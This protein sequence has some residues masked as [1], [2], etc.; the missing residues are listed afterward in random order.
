M[1][2]ALFWPGR[3]GAQPVGDLAVAATALFVAVNGFISPTYLRHYCP[4]DDSGY[5]VDGVEERYF[6]LANFVTAMLGLALVLGEMAAVFGSQ[7][8]DDV[9]RWLVSLAKVS[10]VGTFQL[11]VYVFYLCLKMF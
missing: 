3:P 7:A 9:A 8:F 11:W 1:A 10:T 5:F 6:H 2:L 4:C